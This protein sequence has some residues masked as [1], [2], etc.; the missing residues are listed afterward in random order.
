MNTP[1][2]DP[3]ALLRQLEG[4]SIGENASALGR[5][6]S[7][8]W[9]GF[10]F[11]IEELNLVVPFAD[12]LEV[13]P[14]GEAQPLPLSREW[15]RGVINIR[16]EIYTV[17]DF[18]HFIGR[19]QAASGPADLGQA[20]SGR[21]ASLFLLSNDG[22]KSALLLDS[23][24]SLRAFS[25]DLPKVAFSGFPPVLMPFLS[26]LLM[27]GDQPWGVIDVDTLTSSESF[28]NIGC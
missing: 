7:G 11:N 17:I 21:G 16:G 8:V 28:V 24:V 26:V 1:Q 23:Q 10:A 19:H 2:T 3:L 18:A 15:V 20:D 6:H 27:D 9:H 25:H 13:V 5:E 22:V 12:G 4:A 14:V